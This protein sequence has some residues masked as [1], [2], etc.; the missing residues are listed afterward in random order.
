MNQAQRAREQGE[1]GMPGSNRHPR[2][3]LT[4]EVTHPITPHSRILAIFSCPTCSNEDTSEQGRQACAW[5]GFP[6]SQ[7]LRAPAWNGGSTPRLRTVRTL[8]LAHHRHSPRT[9]G[10]RYDPLSSARVIWLLAGGD[11]DSFCCWCV[12]VAATARRREGTRRNCQLT[13]QPLH[14]PGG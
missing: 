5:R 11:V 3:G 1:E 6:T 14:S 2:R 13:L 9:G 12:P 8:G 10:R 7:P 4:R